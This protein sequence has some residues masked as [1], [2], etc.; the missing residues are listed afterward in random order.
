ME[1]SFKY[2][3]VETSSWF[4]G[5][6]N[7]SLSFSDRR[8][9]AGS[10]VI[11]SPNYSDGQVDFWGNTPST[12]TDWSFVVFSSTDRDMAIVCAEVY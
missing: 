6:F 1:N 3:F 5:P 4:I 9:I 11:N 8:A 7:T 12:F 10:M 2:V